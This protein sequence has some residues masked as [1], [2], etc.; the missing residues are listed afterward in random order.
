MPSSHH[1][2][3]LGLLFLA[4]G[5]TKT[6]QH[7]VANCLPGTPP[8]VETVPKTAVYS[9]RF[10][11]SDGNKVGGVFRSH[12]FLQAGIKAGFSVDENGAVY[13][14]AAEERFAIEVP[15]GH[16]MVWSATYRKPTQFSKEVAKVAA[17][18]GK[19]V[20]IGA[21]A[22]AKGFIEAIVSDDDDCE[23]LEY[24]REQHRRKVLGY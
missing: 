21:G 17:G 23:Q 16:G 6:V 3:L 24:A 14:I 2:L 9:I 10:L 13:A 22:L 12:R 7:R 1:L 18:T 5:C 19:V 20:G 4:A 8:A 15:P 11:D